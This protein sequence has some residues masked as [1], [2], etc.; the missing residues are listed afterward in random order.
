MVKKLTLGMGYIDAELKG[1]DG[2][3]A[4]AEGV[5]RSISNDCNWTVVLCYRDILS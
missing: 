1:Y 2:D 4:V 5:A 3:K